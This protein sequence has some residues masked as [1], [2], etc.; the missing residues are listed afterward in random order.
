MTASTTRR[1]DVGSGA[2]R[3]EFGSKPG[4]RLRA[5]HALS[6]ATLRP[7]L[8]GLAT[9]AVHGPLRGKPAFRISNAAELAT[10]PLRPSRGTRMRRVSFPDFR[11]E[12]VWHRDHPSPDDP[13]AGAILYFHG[14]AFVGGGLHSHRRLVGR[15]ARDSGVPVFNVDYRQLPKAGII[16]AYA[17]GLQAYEHLLAQ[18][19]AADKIVL[20]GDSAGGGIAFAIALAVRDEGLPMPGGI[21]AISPW[22]NLDPEPHR[23]HPNNR[24]DAMLSAKILA[25]SAVSG[26]ADGGELDPAWSPVNHDFT[27]LPPVLIQMGSEEVL[28]PD[29]ELLALRCADAGV[30]YTLQIWEKAIHVFHAAADVIPEAREALADVVQFV[31]EVVSPTA[32]APAPLTTIRS[33]R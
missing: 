14:G 18:G 23:Q 8:D 1:V 26:L 31:C 3:V 9:L 13:A 10:I 17:D 11:A 27:G 21:A 5:L 24:R 2:V 6:R 20:A 7:A 33:D 16:E 19:L 32:V 15:I 28:L 22:A 30:P 12:W 29:A 4:L 25:M